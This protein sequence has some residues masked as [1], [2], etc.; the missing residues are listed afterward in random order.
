MAAIHHNDPDLIWVQDA[1][2]EY[3]PSRSTL[4]RL[5]DDGTIHA[6]EFVGDRRKFLR[7]SELDAILGKPAKDVPGRDGQAG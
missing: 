1:T 3:G 5:I 7:R 2:A 6:V 4:D